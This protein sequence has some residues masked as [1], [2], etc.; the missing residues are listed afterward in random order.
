MGDM[1]V[2]REDIDLTRPNENRNKTAG[3]TDKERQS[4]EQQ[5]QSGLLYDCWR[6]LHPEK[7][8]FTYFSRRF[9]CRSKG[10]GWRLDY[11]VASKQLSHLV[12]SCEIMDDY[13]GPSDHIPVMLSI[14]RHALIE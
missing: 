3:F 14:D 2:C 9:N 10:I 12:R 7:Q 4:F 1:N 13:Y 8:Q 11:A 5:L 6:E